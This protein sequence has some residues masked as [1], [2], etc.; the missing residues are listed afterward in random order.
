[1][2]TLV[3]AMFL[4][5]AAW[6]SAEERT[7]KPLTEEEYQAKLDKLSRPDRWEYRISKEG[8]VTRVTPTP[9][10]EG[11]DIDWVRKFCEYKRESGSP[12]E[13]F[14]VYYFNVKPGGTPLPANNLYLPKQTNPSLLPPKTGG[15]AGKPAAQDAGKDDSTPPAIKEADVPGTYDVYVAGKLIGEMELKEGGD[16]KDWSGNSGVTYRWL[17]RDKT[18]TV[19]LK[20]EF[21]RLQYTRDGSFVGAILTLEK[22]TRQAEAKKEPVPKDDPPKVPVATQ[23]VAGK[24]EP[25][26]G[27][28]AKSDAPPTAKDAPKPPA[29]PD[30]P[31]KEAE[32]PP[33][34]VVRDVYPTDKE[35]EAVR[36]L[37]KVY[38]RSNDYKDRD[39]ARS[40]VIRLLNRLVPARGEQLSE[41]EWTKRFETHKK[42]GED[43]G[44]I[45]GSSTHRFWNTDLCNAF[46]DSMISS[47][48][49]HAAMFKQLKWYCDNINKLQMERSCIRTAVYKYIENNPDKFPDD[50]AKKLFCEQIIK[51]GIVKDKGL[52]ELADSYK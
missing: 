2:K 48:K 4:L 27:E 29:E 43:F 19:Q 31:P 16:L 13:P 17:L 21:Q 11:P 33:K 20:G 9:A 5:S 45:S 51:S 22:R 7:F 1:M 46:T 18:L 49:S 26:K 52:Q 15:E 34:A 25:V 47:Q 36:D 24:G 41:E 44:D 39:K 10:T 23:E 50:A 30:W 42:M 6:I 3:I 40:E 35:L 12:R 32:W 14:R 8:I 28:A 38:K 37:V